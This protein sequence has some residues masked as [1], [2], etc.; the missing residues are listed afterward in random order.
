MCFSHL[1]NHGVNPAPVVDYYPFTNT[2]LPITSLEPIHKAQRSRPS[3]RP[4]L[5]RKGAKC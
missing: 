1:L 5:T 4:L 2:P 3:V